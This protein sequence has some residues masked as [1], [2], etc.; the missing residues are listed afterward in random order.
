MPDPPGFVVKKGTKRLAVSE[1]P[2]PSSSTEIS[3]WSPFFD[4]PRATQQVLGSGIG[5]AQV[6][7]GVKG[8]NCNI[9][10]GHDLAE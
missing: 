4:Q 6:F 1:R 7:S 9:D 5:K 10:F 8:E 3:K 2:G